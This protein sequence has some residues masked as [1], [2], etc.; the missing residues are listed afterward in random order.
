MD[1]KKQIIENAIELA[2]KIG[3]EKPKVALLSALEVVNPAIK[4]TVEAAILS[5]MGIEDK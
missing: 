1:D 5:K 2:I 4:D 3:Y